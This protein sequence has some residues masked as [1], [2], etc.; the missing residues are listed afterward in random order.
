MKK[1]L[2]LASIAFFI[3]CGKNDTQT[4]LTTPSID[5]I[6]Q[7]YYK[8]FKNDAD[9]HN[10][11]YGDSNIRFIKIAY[12]SEAT[13]TPSTAYHMSQCLTLQSKNGTYYKELLIDAA[14]RAIGSEVF[15]NKIFLHEIGACAY[16]LPNSPDNIVN[17]IMHS[18]IQIS[19]TDEFEGL[20]QQFFDDAK[21]NGA[22]WNDT[23]PL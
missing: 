15:R 2:L 4:N 20:K 18:P 9:A 17:A 14:F 11:E 12:F 6:L 3:A 22:H 23:D 1:I 7:P 5:A 16:H 8:N 19:S 10:V 13:L 21:T